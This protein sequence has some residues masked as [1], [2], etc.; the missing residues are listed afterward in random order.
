MMLCVALGKFSRRWWVLCG[1]GPLSAIVWGF[2]Y[3]EGLTLEIGNTFT[4]I[5]LS[6]YSGC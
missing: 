2:A 1:N 5:F 3:S 4:T 6:E